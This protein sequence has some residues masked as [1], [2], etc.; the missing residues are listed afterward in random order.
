MT[1]PNHG[2]TPHGGRGFASLQSSARVPLEASIRR[3]AAGGTHGVLRSGGAP[4]GSRRCHSSS[5]AR[6][7]TDVA[8]IE[9]LIAQGAGRVRLSLF[10]IGA[11]SA[12][13][14]MASYAPSLWWRRDCVSSFR[15]PSLCIGNA[16]LLGFCGHA[17][18]PAADRPHSALY[19]H[20]AIEQCGLSISFPVCMVSSPAGK[21]AL[22]L[23]VGS[24]VSVTPL[25][26]TSL[27]GAFL[28]NPRQPTPPCL[29]PGCCRRCQQPPR[30]QP[31]QSSAT[32]TRSP[33]L[34]GYTATVAFGSI[35]GPLSCMHLRG[36]VQHGC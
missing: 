29:T 31:R 34:R 4:C 8:S 11:A 15:H 22:P 30:R 6:E 35:C 16:G 26:R 24:V 20:F 18:T 23:Q 9:L 27:A 21:C 7:N 3:G 19:G 13:I 1:P 5:P 36:N 28:R 25:V 2:S 32:T 12:P 10:A 14:A 17:T 33:A